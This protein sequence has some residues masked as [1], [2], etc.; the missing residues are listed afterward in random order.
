ML[1]T[2]HA[3]CNRAAASCSQARTNT[4]AFETPIPDPGNT[5][6]LGIGSL[7]SFW[8]PSPSHE[9]FQ[10]TDSEGFRLPM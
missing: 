2:R 3:I 8:V 6:V 10:K 7:R 9:M 4:T 1:D 5:D